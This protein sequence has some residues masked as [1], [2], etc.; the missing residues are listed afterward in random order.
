MNEHKILIID[1]QPINIELIVKILEETDE[2]YTMYQAINGEMGNDVA[3]KIVPDLIITDWE[4]PGISGIETIIKIKSDDTTKNIP[5]IMASGVMISS[6]NLRTALEAGA[7]DFI[8]KPIDKI[9]LIARVRSILLLAD[10]YKEIRHQKE[11]LEENNRQLSEA[12]EKVRTLRG[13]LPICSSCKK[14]RDDKGYWSEVEVYVRDHSDARFSHGICPDC[15][16]ELYP[17]MY[18]KIYSKTQ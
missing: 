8:R 15:V 13:L 5:I 1:D 7:V 6:E 12:L 10:S 14:I 16:K 3:K 17:D 4:M 9:E 2:P 11:E 18:D